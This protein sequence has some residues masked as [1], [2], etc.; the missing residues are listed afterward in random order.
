MSA[1]D[2]LASAVTGHSRIVIVVMLLLTAGVGAGMVD[3]TQSSSITDQFSTGSVEEE[4][5][6]Y[7]EQN[8][9]AGRENTTTVQVIVR[10]ED[11]N[12]LSRESLLRSLRFQQSLRN[13]ATIN[14]SLADENAIVGVENYVAS[15]GLLQASS[16]DLRA[17]NRS[18]QENVTALERRQAA[19]NDTSDRLRNRLPEA[20]GPN[21][22]AAEAFEQVRRNSTVNLTDADGE[23]YAQAAELLRTAEGQEEQQRAAYAMATYAGPDNESVLRE[24]YADLQARSA[25]IEARGDELAERAA[26]L[27]QRRA[28]IQAGDLPPLDE[29]IVAVEAMNESEVS[30]LVETILS[31]GDEGGSGGAV[32]LMSANYQPGSTTADARMMVL[33]QKTSDGLQNAGEVSSSISETQVMIGDEAEAASEDGERYITFGF[34]IISEETQQS[35]DDSLAIVGPL[36]LLFVLVTLLIAYRDIVDIV[37]GFVGIFTVLIWTFGF[38]G[39][40][41]ITFN[42]IMIAVPVLLIG[43][44]IDYAIHIFMRHREQRQERGTAEDENVRGSMR[45]ALVGVGIALVWVTATTVIGFLSNLTSP[46][47]PIQDFGIVSSFGIAVALLVFGAFVPALKVEIDGALE[48]RGIDRKKR[49]FGTGG[50]GFSAAL[51]V[52]AKAAKAAPL[53][54][55]VLVLTVSVA[56]AYG[57]TQVDTSFSNE[58]FIA[59]DPPDYMYDLPEPFRPGEYTVKQNLEYINDNFQ[60]QDQTAQILIEGNVTHPDTLTRVDRAEQAVADRDVAFVDS[61]GNP[62]VTSPNSVIRDVAER[63]GTM[64]AVV[65]ETDTDGDG[66]PDR[67]LA[68]VYDTL[69]EVAPEQAT[70]VVYR[71]GG[72]YRAVQ[73]EVS[74][75]GGLS[76]SETTDRLQAA[77]GVV[78]DDGESGVWTATATGTPVVNEIIQG[79]LLNTVIESLL[80]T[81]VAVFAFLMVAY[82]VT[83]GSAT[84][85]IITL[86]PV[87]LSVS[88]ILGTMYVIGMPFNVLTGM[89]TS[90]TVGLG[91]AYSIHLSERYNLELERRGDVWEAM[92]TSVTGTGGALL[93]SAATTVGGFGVLALAIFPALQQFGIITGLTIVYAFLASVVVLPSL[94]VVWTKYLSPDDIPAP[95]D[96]PVDEDDDPDDG[97]AADDGADGGDGGGTDP[98]AGSP[99]DDDPEGTADD[100]VDP[101]TAGGPPADAGSD[102]QA[103]A[104]EA[105]SPATR[106]VYPDEAAPGDEFS[107]SVD[108][109]GVSGRVVLVEDAPG[110]GGEITTLDPDPATV[111]QVGRTVYAAWELDG[112]TDLHLAYTADAPADA[113]AGEALAFDGEV[114]TADGTHPTGGPDE[115]SVVSEFLA[116]VRERSAPTTADVERAAELV[117][118]GDLTEA[119]LER[120]YERWLAGTERTTPPSRPDGGED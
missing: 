107:V 67:D 98:L 103:A 83:E 89:I 30:S 55:I 2:R 28:A 60:R 38:M 49:A 94:L 75:R 39:W 17:A 63:N 96:A 117:A 46:L 25:E 74:V 69:Y 91:V 90:L 20:A 40:A 102:A 54:V 48:N 88:W 82:R 59:D 34:G 37:L 57:A 120:I 16:R 115:L 31:G 65:N 111:S 5:L 92:E 114:R 3:V 18:L 6:D 13:N 84:L 7:V 21:K 26:R 73:I 4:K 66:L 119:E 52:G 12:V 76:T 106:T 58:D 78:D 70:T 45:T 50:G 116:R 8:F 109:D 86:L 71:D 41:D 77:A 43:L 95:G 27:E 10:N 99:T 113:T 101:L 81:L 36:A 51:S 33:Y 110:V 53:V 56:G 29:Q 19:L 64:A 80:I 93:G 112:P 68:R 87:A 11:G 118:A 44:S 104:D 1:M 15:F 42:Q 62:S 23:T 22:T 100:G 35:M 24:E 97:G 14:E 72:E 61:G 79:E 32:Q 108:V 85:G 47:S 105:A 9:T